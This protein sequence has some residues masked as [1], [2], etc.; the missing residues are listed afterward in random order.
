MQESQDPPAAEGSS[1]QATAPLNPR[2]A[3]NSGTSGGTGSPTKWDFQNPG[4]TRVPPVLWTRE[5]GQGLFR[6]RC[7][8]EPHRDSVSKFS[9]VST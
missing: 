2:L 5:L 6:H 9:G 7:L 1:A 3:R 8:A 4:Q